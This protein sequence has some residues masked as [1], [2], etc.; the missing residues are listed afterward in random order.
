MILLVSV[1]GYGVEFPLHVSWGC[2]NYASF[3]FFFFFLIAEGPDAVKF[4]VNHATVQAIFCVA[5]TLNS[6]SSSICCLIFLFFLKAYLDDTEI[7]KK[8]KTFYP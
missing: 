3:F 7:K 5:E 2:S 8:K 6:V 1:S 4:I